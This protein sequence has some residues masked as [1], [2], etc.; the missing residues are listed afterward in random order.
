MEIPEIQNKRKNNIIV[1][2]KDQTWKKN[3]KIAQ[4]EISA[5]KKLHKKGVI[6]YILE[7]PA[8][9]SNLKVAMNLSIAPKCY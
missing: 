8:Q 1:K 9:Q 7:F 4:T 2:V 5:K 3:V 6:H